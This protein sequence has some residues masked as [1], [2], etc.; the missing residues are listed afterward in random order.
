MRKAYNAL[1]HIH[2]KDDTHTLEKIVE[3]A[4]DWIAHNLR[5]KGLKQ[6]M[7]GNLDLKIDRIHL[8]TVIAGEEG[9]RHFAMMHEIPDK[10]NRG[11]R[12]NTTF[13]V[14]EQGDDRFLTAITLSQRSQED[15]ITPSHYRVIRPGLVNMLI[16]RFGAH[17]KYPLRT[18]PTTVRQGGA[19]CFADK[20]RDEERKHPIV[21]ISCEN[22]T[23]KPLVDTDLIANQL[24]G[25]A[26]VYVAENKHVTFEMREEIGKNLNCYN[27]AVRIYWP[28]TRNSHN[29]MHEIWIPERINTKRHFHRHLL[30][31]IARFSTGR[32]PPITYEI[33][34]NM[35]M[36][37]DIRD[38]REKH[39]EA[40]SG[41]EDFE[42]VVTLYEQ[43]LQI[44]KKELQEA[45]QKAE[46]AEEAGRSLTARVMKLETALEA[47]KGSRKA[48]PADPQGIETMQDVLESID[49]QYQDSIMILKKARNSCKKS[50]YNN[51]EQVFKALEWLATRYLSA[52]KGTGGNDLEKSCLEQTG[53]NYR[54]KQSRVTMGENPS[55]Y[56]VKWNK[57]KV[58]LM[59]HL[60][61]GS[62]GDEQSTIRIAFF[63]DDSAEKVVVGYIGK[64]QRNRY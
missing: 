3:T 36:T 49:G 37:S 44:T 17:G 13:C 34:E 23:Q 40:L 52:R 50:K 31:M 2:R 5:G 47:K 10:Y 30:N 27:G 8:K 42:Q 1:F 48:G 22:S 28:M 4:K 59:E 60:V 64:H 38:L 20:I 21:Y 7:E 29:V 62:S 33:I 55:D 18:R 43:E 11:S 16:D 26:H 6:F 24:A 57:K 53:M 15:A 63:Y 58:P 35:K 14:A 25:L 39:S 51:P 61:Q 54:H 41:N 56:F 19:K 46:E 45:R 12:K 9:S 32:T